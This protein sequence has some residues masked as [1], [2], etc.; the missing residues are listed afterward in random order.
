MVA[1]KNTN[2][3]LEEFYQDI[4]KTI[5]K[6][7]SDSDYGNYLLARV[8]GG[9]KKVFNKTQTEIRNFDMSFLDQI[10]STYPA[11]LKIMK[12]P[13][14][15]LR[16]EQEIVA[17]EK[18]R[19]VN[20]DTVRHLSSHTHLI[21]DIKGDDVIPS[22]VL[23]TYAEEEI[24]T[25][26]NRF[27]KSLVKRIEMFIE[28]RYDLMKESIESYETERLNVENNF[29][30]SGQDVTIKLDVAIKNDITVNPEVTKEQYERLLY[31]RDQIQA[32]KGTEFMR[33]LAKAHDVLPPIMKTNIILHN[34]DFKLCYL[35]W[36]YLDD[37]DSFGT[38]I[39]IS[40]KAY[41]YS[42]EFE[43]DINDVMM[44]ALTSFIKNRDISDIYV[45]KKV[46]QVKAPRVTKNEEIDLELNLKPDNAKME[47]YRMNELLLQQ[48]AK[49]F[50]ASMDANYEV[51]GK[52]FESVRVVYRQMQEMLDQ[53]Y[54]KS[55]NLN[56]DKDDKLNDY[57]LLDTLRN[58][59]E[60]LKI[61]HQLK[62]SNILKMSKE[63]K[64]LQTQI[65]K[66]E[67]KIAKDEIERNKKL[68]EEDDDSSGSDE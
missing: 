10:E 37:T 21:K 59:L 9:K 53:I 47:D 38:N 62:Q 14:K 8:K 52:Y 66:L 54:H 5:D 25:Y 1:K 35:L 31:V 7:T 2:I 45:P 48:T 41:R 17:V 11:I 42:S 28:H 26:E 50:D 15:S 4:Y 33:A 36:M 43:N 23:T 60:T 40:E 20:S 44:L 61:I 12:A 68:N 63:E 3:D 34:P 56:D 49:F 58:R 55:F 51:S 32:L 27:I 39:D 22:K 24:A 46:S 13:K 16:Y 65:E 67:D 57:D 30:L 29:F 18:A 19:K 64:T 6:G